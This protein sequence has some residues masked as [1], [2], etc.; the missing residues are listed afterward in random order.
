[1]TPRAMEQIVYAK[2][3]RWVVFGQERLRAAEPFT[4]VEEI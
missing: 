3:P 2:D 4:P 1:M